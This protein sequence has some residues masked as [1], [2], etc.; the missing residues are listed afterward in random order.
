MAAHDLLA[1]YG[2]L[3]FYNTLLELLGCAHMGR[4]RVEQHL[5]ALTAV[6]D[7]AKAVVTTPFPF[8]ADLSD[9]ARPSR[10]MEARN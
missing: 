8:A 7:G 10:S 1:N 2:H 3:A 5:K 6:F 9:S 4:A